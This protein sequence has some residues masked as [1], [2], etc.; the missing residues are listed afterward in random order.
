MEAHR[1]RR[2]RHIDRRDGDK[3]KM[4]LLLKKERLRANRIRERRNKDSGADLTNG[5]TDRNVNG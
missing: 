1:Q 3:K 2:W 4:K 5:Q